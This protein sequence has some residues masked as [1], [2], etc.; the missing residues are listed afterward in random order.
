MSCAISTSGGA[1]GAESSEPAMG[2]ETQEWVGDGSVTEAGGGELSSFF[3]DP[4][5]QALSEA[6]P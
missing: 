6:W 4:L 1:K 2:W 3:L 5:P